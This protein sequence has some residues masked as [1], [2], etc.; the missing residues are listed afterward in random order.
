M[1]QILAVAIAVFIV[2]EIAF[3]YVYNSLLPREFLWQTTGQKTDVDKKLNTCFLI[4]IIFFIV[5]CAIIVFLQYFYRLFPIPIAAAL[6]ATPLTLPAFIALQEEIKV[7]NREDRYPAYIRSLGIAAETKTTVASEVLKKLRYH[8]FGELTKN[9]N[10]LYKRL[11]LRID[12]LKSW[13]YFE[14]E[15][16]SDLIARFCDMYVRGA[17]AG[18]SPKEISSLISNNY[19]N[20]MQLRKKRFQ[21]ASTV[22]G[23]SYGIAVAVAF[24]LYISIYLVDWMAEISAGIEYPYIITGIEIPLL[25][26]VTIDITL[27]A[28]IAIIVI[29]IYALFSAIIIHIF[30]IDHRLKISLHF[31]GLL[32]TCAITAVLVDIMMRFLVGG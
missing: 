27:L 18:G 19:V 13:K 30:N 14:A 17:R 25:M 9:I 16:G 6:A 31:A 24:S 10:D 5:V 26:G 12:E 1:V 20:L 11:A 23:M 22:V 32:W 21:Q 7:K 4:S 29:A 28:V 3:L 15:T 2:V 8:D